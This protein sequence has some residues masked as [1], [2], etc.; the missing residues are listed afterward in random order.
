MHTRKESINR[1]KNINRK[2]NAER[3]TELNQTRKIIRNMTKRW[4]SANIHRKLIGTPA[5]HKTISNKS[6]AFEYANFIFSLREK[7]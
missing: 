5:S 6:I 2:E 3:K 1:K 7:S 4:Y